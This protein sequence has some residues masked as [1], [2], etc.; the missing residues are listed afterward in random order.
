MTDKR[1]CSQACRVAVAV[2]SAVAI[3][4]SM[5]PRIAVAAA[6][7]EVVFDV[8]ILLA[9]ASG[10]GLLAWPIVIVYIL[11]LS[12][13]VAGFTALARSIPAKLAGI[14]G[15]YV[16]KG[17]YEGLLSLSAA[18]P[19]R[20]TRSLS[21]GLEDRDGEILLDKAA[22]LAS[23]QAL[24]ESCFLPARAIKA[25]AWIVISIAALGVGVEL[26][27]LYVE[28]YS[29]VSVVMGELP[30]RDL[31]QAGSA[32][33]IVLGA[34]GLAVFTVSLVS[35]ILFSGAARVMLAQRTSFIVGLLSEA[36]MARMEAGGR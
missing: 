24:S 32:N 3:G 35:G 12:I 23:W 20:F 28:V 21:A 17:D 36:G 18:N 14:A 25:Y 10:V 30:L 34:G 8:G 31:L 1:R 2:T 27:R 5:V 4:L 22:I 19:S 9:R 29:R 15:D 13:N 6:Q 11:L 33:V 26:V 16:R 7:Q